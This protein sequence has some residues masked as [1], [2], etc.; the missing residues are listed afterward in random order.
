MP[1]LDA[2]LLAIAGTPVSSVADVIASFTAIDA[3]LPETDGLKWFNSLY[4]AVTRAVDGN[5]NSGEWRNVEWITTLDIV[6][7]RLY[8]DAL[9]KSL[10]PGAAPS[11]C[12]QVLFQ[13]RHDAR[14]ARIQFALAGVN[15][16]IDHDLSVAVVQACGQLGLAPVHLSPQYQDYCHVNSV[17]DGLVEQAKQDLLV[18]LLGND[19]PHI[20]LV[21]NLTA[22]W[23][24]RTTREVAWTNA[25]LLWL[26][27][28]VPGLEDRILTG[29]DVKAE[30][31]GRGLLAPV[32][33]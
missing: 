15:A 13:A 32:G 4:L 16:H 28:S 30:L 23:G 29:L 20:D 5:L 33:I 24:L 19:L 6:F 22:Q 31:V 14:L 21:E 26:A 25:E 12:W 2:Q 9:A 17:L 7:A 3:A 1:A 11:K 18:G 8:L 10:T 27:R